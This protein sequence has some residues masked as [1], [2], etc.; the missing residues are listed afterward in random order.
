MSLGFF[1][2]MFVVNFTKWFLFCGGWS[3]TTFVDMG[4]VLCRLRLTRVCPHCDQIS[5]KTGV[6]VASW[7]IVELNV[8]GVQSLTAVRH[9]T[10]VIVTSCWLPVQPFFY[11]DKYILQFKQI[12]FLI[13]RNIC[14]NLDKYISQQ[15]GVNAELLLA[16]TGLLL[17]SHCFQV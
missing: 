1:W 11:L 2:N 6:K 15:C 10:W 4:S 3:Y 7:L 8:A 17:W 14:L 9:Q 5:D 12:H 16:P 13:W